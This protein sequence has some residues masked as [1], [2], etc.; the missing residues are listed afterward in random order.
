VQSSFWDLQNFHDCGM[1]RYWQKPE[2]FH[3]IQSYLKT[4]TSEC[5]TFVSAL[6]DSPVLNETTYKAWRTFQKPRY[7]PDRGQKKPY[8][9][10]KLGQ[11][12]MSGMRNATFFM[13]KE[14]SWDLIKFHKFEGVNETRG[15]NDYHHPQRNVSSRL[16][17][18]A[19]DRLQ[20]RLH[21]VKSS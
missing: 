1:L 3:H 15:K 20:V 10:N 11:N 2:D 4:W 12:L 14:H 19:L 5:N 8:W 21:S 6:N 13:A 9:T 18:Y 16:V 17:K 7:Y